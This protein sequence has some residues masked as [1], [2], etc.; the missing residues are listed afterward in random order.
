MDDDDEDKDSEAF[1]SST[2][3]STSSFSNVRMTI[4]VPRV[5]DYFTWSH[6]GPPWP[7][8]VIVTSSTSPTPQTAS[9]SARAIFVLEAFPNP[10]PIPDPS[11]QDPLNFRAIFFRPLLSSL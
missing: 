3:T 8:G 9:F 2:S 4:R 5:F 1:I 11:S 7:V 10:N 6:I